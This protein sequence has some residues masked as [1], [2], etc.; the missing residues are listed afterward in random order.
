M[1]TEELDAFLK[2][3]A[4]PAP[5][6]EAPPPAPETSPPPPTEPPPPEAPKSEDDDGEPPTPVDGEAVVPRR[7]LEDERHKRQDWKVKATRFETEAAELRKQL[8]ELKKPPP[9]APP[10]AREPLPPIDP[11]VDPQGYHARTQQ[12]MLNERL[13]MSEMLMRSQIGDDKVD[14]AVAEFKT[15]AEADPTLYG[16]LYQ[17]ANP[18]GWMAKEV[19]RMRLQRE[20]GDDPAK[21]REAERARIREELAAEQPETPQPP[22]RSAIANLPP[23]LASVRSAAPRSAPTY[24]GPPS[25]DDILA[26]VGR[27]K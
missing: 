7:A 14:A 9:A 24:S 11:S 17:Q 25:L 19:E 26:E 3:D 6:P 15:A 21:W 18:Y 8:E 16:K 1:A 5:A 10:A 4:E 2:G 27:R 20:I 23:S 13:N 22:A 12:V